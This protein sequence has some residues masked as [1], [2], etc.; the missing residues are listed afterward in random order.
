MSE[1]WRDSLSNFNSLEYKHSERKILR[2][3]RDFYGDNTPISRIKV[4]KLWKGSVLALVQIHFFNILYSGVMDIQDE[5]FLQNKLGQFEVIGINMKSIDVPTVPPN[6]ITAYNISSRSILVKWNDIPKSQSNGNLTSF[7]VLYSRNKSK[8]YTE[9]VLDPNVYHVILKNLEIFYP[10]SIRVVAHNR[11]GEGVASLPIVVWTEM[12]APNAEPEIQSS[13]NLTSTSVYVHWSAI[14]KENHLGILLGY[15]IKYRLKET[16]EWTLT[17]LNVTTQDIVLDGLKKFSVYEVTVAGFNRIGRGP[18]SRVYITTDEDVPSE[19]PTGIKV[20]N[21]SSTSLRLSWKVIPP[22]H[23]NGILR[24][25]GIFYRAEH[26]HVW[27]NLTVQPDIHSLELSGLKKYQKYYIQVAGLTVK[28]IGKPC[29]QIPVMTDQDIPSVAPPDVLAV[30]TSSTSLLIEWDPLP[31]AQTHGILLGYVVFYKR[32]AYRNRPWVLRRTTPTTRAVEIVGLRKFTKYN[33]QVAGFTSKGVGKKSKLF[34]VP[35]GEDTPSRSVNFLTARA[36]SSTSIKV[37]WGQIP[38]GMVHGMLRGYKVLF[39]TIDDDGDFMVNKT[40]PTTYEIILK[41]LLK[42][43]KYS[44]RVIGYTIKGNGKASNDINCT[45]FE[46]LPSRPPLHIK[47]QSRWSS[48]EIPVT[49]QPITPPYFVH[50]ILRGYRIKYKPVRDTLKPINATFTWDEIGPDKLEYLIR[51]LQPF[52][53]YVVQVLAFTSVGD[54]VE[55]E[56]GYGETCSCQ[57]VFTS[58]WWQL[59]PYTTVDEDKAI[60]IFPDILKNAIEF[61]CLDCVHG[62]AASINF[63]GT[64]KT[65][66]LQRGIIEVKD[67]LREEIDF[68]FPI[69]GTQYKT[70][71][72]NGFPYVPLVHSPGAVFLISSRNEFNESDKVMETILTSWTFIVVLILLSYF[73]GLI[74]WLVERKDNP[75]LFNESFFYGPW[76]GFWWSF[77]TVTTVGYGD[78]TPKT[79]LG[80]SIAIIWTMWGQIMVVMLV[81]QITSKISAGIIGEE[82]RVYGKKVAVIQNSSE[83]RLGVKK[84]A[85]YDPDVHYSNLKEIY[86]DLVNHKVFGALIDT[87]TVASATDLFN[88]AKLTVN[89]IFDYSLNYGVVLG[90]GK[91]GNYN[92]V[93]STI[94][95]KKQRKSIMLL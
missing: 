47:V 58:N 32:R 95:N 33:I 51:G 7:V 52:T 94:S 92:L 60:G 66:S 80:R 61:C 4:L 88:D 12:E 40:F 76:D 2:N 18:E 86:D 45:T 57:R 83:Y 43:T 25:Y 26:V 63:V 28:G 56:P 46:D 31:Q 62:H 70:T 82:I 87:Y 68:H 30:N 24:G 35:T 78:K 39:R 65:K 71:Y 8:E 48:T 19:H 22:E 74:M 20:V 21:T 11:R 85:I 23:I 6:N 29:K 73:V 44:I 90:G 93:L 91:D 38:H 41:N 15:E 64:N 17:R 34:F 3:V 5:I 59:I 77:I 50:G 27:N 89:N 75:K 53:T 81:A 16:D 36:L 9:T 72:G 84:N 54:G 49:W 42:Y 67:N 69:F 55:S 79:V 37:K 1:K 14:P 13:Y 10:Y